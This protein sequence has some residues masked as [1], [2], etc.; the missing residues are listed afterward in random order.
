MNLG[1][2]EYTTEDNDFTGVGNPGNTI[3]HT[4]T[5]VESIDPSNIEPET[6]YKTEEGLILESTTCNLIVDARNFI[7]EFEKIKT[8]R[9][10]YN[11][12]IETDWIKSIQDAYNETGSC[13]LTKNPTRLFSLEQTT[14]TEENEIKRYA[15]HLGTQSKYWVRHLETTGT[16]KYSDDSIMNASEQLASNLNTYL[17]HVFLFYTQYQVNVSTL[18][19]EVNNVKL[20]FSDVETF[21]PEEEIKSIKNI[22]NTNNTADILNELIKLGIF[23][24][25]KFHA[26]YLFDGDILRFV[27]ELKLTDS[28]HHWEHEHPEKEMEITH[29]LQL[30][31]IQRTDNSCLP[32]RTFRSWISCIYQQI[33]TLNNTLME[34]KDK[35]K[36]SAIQNAS[37]IHTLGVKIQDMKRSLTSSN[38]MIEFLKKKHAKEIESL[39]TQLSA[40]S[41]SEEQLM[42]LKHIYSSKSNDV[43]L[44]TYGL[45]HGKNTHPLLNLVHQLLEISTKNNDI[46]DISFQLSAEQSVLPNHIVE[47]LIKVGTDPTNTNKMNDAIDI[48]EKYKRSF[49][50]EEDNINIQLE[51]CRTNMNSTRLELE[52]LYKK[53]TEIQL[54]KEIQEKQ[55][56]SILLEKESLEQTIASQNQNLENITRTLQENVSNLDQIKTKIDT[57][58]ENQNTS[59]QEYLS[60]CET[61]RELYRKKSIAEKYHSQ[62]V[63]QLE[64][65]SQSILHANRRHDVVR[66]QHQHLI[67][68]YTEKEIQ[69]AHDISVLMHTEGS[70]DKIKDDIQIL[71]EKRNILVE[72]KQRI[73]NDLVGMELLASWNMKEYTELKKNIVND[74]ENVHIFDNYIQTIIQKLQQKLMSIGDTNK[75]LQS[76]NK[77]LIE[78]VQSLRE[79]I[80]ESR[81]MI[82]T[83]SAE[84]ASLM[85]TVEKMESI[86][87]SSSNNTNQH[88]LSTIEFM[89][90]QIKLLEAH[91]K[92]LQNQHHHYEVQVKQ[93]ESTLTEVK[94]IN[95]VSTDFNAVSNDHNTE[96]QQEQTKYLES[97]HSLSTL[98]PIIRQHYGIKR[99]LYDVYKL[100]EIMKL[101]KKIYQT[102]QRVDLINRRKVFGGA[103]GDFGIT[104]VDADIDI[105]KFMKAASYSASAHR[106]IK[107]YFAEVFLPRWRYRKYKE[108]GI[109]RFPI[110]SEFE[111]MIFNFKMTIYAQMKQKE[112]ENRERV[113]KERYKE[114]L[115]AQHEGFNEGEWEWEYYYIDDD[116][117]EV[118][119]R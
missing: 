70:L 41:Q 66:Q 107:K 39:Q 55:K 3:Q 13:G 12:N 93:M 117:N 40:Y 38:E 79:L 22:I 114:E 52:S 68:Q 94:N 26:E 30:N 60:L 9:V 91:N 36:C 81:Q 5:V 50:N 28:P 56:E 101:C 84:K 85:N 42:E 105:T 2:E 78:K 104:P 6:P 35:M 95:F 112:K 64:V 20:K 109:N 15:Y 80:I 98:L 23:D 111:I 25:N 69:Y 49:E 110:P 92:T 18:H 59:S 96:L 65:L 74:I 8:Q 67:E 54:Q 51:A 73:K 7:N 62:T 57:N 11:V 31:L 1:N 37:H 17:I 83:L 77:S 82:S 4:Y 118:I 33:D 53:Q 99:T 103:D 58:I 63:Q 47:K 116:G 44:L 27:V 100:T 32:K 34:L 14:Q 89:S 10:Y 97:L 71:E 46:S 24:Q 88:S 48:I 72:K 90:Q 119:K 29:V 43:G 87:S 106:T 45:Q 75:A 61:V 21:I 19:N 102:K 16:Y 115:A 113:K 86:I 108:D 76:E